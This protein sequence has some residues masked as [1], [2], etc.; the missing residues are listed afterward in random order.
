M[1]KVKIDP[2]KIW[3]MPL[4]MGPVAPERHNRVGN[5]YGEVEWVGLQY[6]TDPDAVRAVL[7]D[8]YRPAEKPT[9][10][11][12]FCYNDR[13]D[14]LCGRG[15]RWATVSVSAR[16]DGEQDHVEGDY[17]L[18]MYE[19]DGF[20]IITGRELHGVHKI[21][22]DIS[23]VKTS[24]SG[25][26][27]CDVSLWGHMLFGIEL[28]PLKEQNLIVRSVAAKEVS[29]RPMLGYKYIPCMDG[30]PDAAYP[31]TMSNELKV[32]QLWFG[33]SGEV[34]YG[35]A[36]EKQI[37]LTVQILDALKTL[38][39]REVTRTFRFRGSGL[40]RSD[41]SRRLR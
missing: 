12:V 29:N 25:H 3:M 35:D 13:V 24:G 38:P 8:C 37:G 2:D 34:F 9:V 18:V 40:L 11:V 4:I 23:P 14:F 10:S 33:K 39:V 16:F 32:E 7:P 26:L 28:A 5:V 30:P 19:D 36:N 31:T 20:A 27:R 21:F 17:N 41:L 22:G 1:R 6:R 15:Y